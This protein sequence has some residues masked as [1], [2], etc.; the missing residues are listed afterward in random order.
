MLLIAGPGTGS[1]RCSRRIVEINRER[2]GL[3][4]Y[5][6]SARHC[7]VKHGYAAVSTERQTRANEILGSVD[8]CPRGKGRPSSTAVASRAK[9]KKPRLWMVP[10]SWQRLLCGVLCFLGLVLVVIIE[11]TRSA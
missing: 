10:T 6:I 7:L 2:C 9:Q 4:R 3:R 8:V 5:L 1:S 11:C